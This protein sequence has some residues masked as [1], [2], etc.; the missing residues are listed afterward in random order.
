MNIPSGTVFLAK[1]IT[2][3]QDSEDRVETLPNAFSTPKI[4]REFLE[5]VYNTK[6]SWMQPMINMCPKSRWEAWLNEDTEVVVY[7]VYLIGEY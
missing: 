7:E 4:A 1:V 5:D 2:H 3:Y 6:L